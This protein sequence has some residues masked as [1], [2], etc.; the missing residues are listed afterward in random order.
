MKE[1]IGG[2]D[3]A[4]NHAQAMGITE[5]V[6]DLADI[7]GDPI[8]AELFVRAAHFVYAFAQGASS[9]IRHH[10]V[11]QLFSRYGR[12]ITLIDGQDILVLKPGYRIGLA[13]ETLEI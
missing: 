8:E 9:H 10:Q 2:F 13:P 5:R 3:I 7:T 4:M 6:G 12:F 11:S 1:Q